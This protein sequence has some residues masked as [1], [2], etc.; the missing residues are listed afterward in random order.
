MLFDTGTIQI[1]YMA[2]QARGGLVGITPGS[3][4]NPGER[5]LSTAA[6]FTGG[7]GVMIY[8]LFGGGGGDRFDLDRLF[9]LFAPTGSN[10][11]QVRT[12]PLD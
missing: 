4:S 10:A 9:L 8:E 7:S 5:D 2:N 11:Y 12:V 6:P 1:G 3:S